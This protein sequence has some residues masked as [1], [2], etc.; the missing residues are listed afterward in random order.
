MDTQLF[1]AL[2]HVA[3][4]SMTIGEMI[5]GVRMVVDGNTRVSINGLWRWIFL[6]DNAFDV[7]EGGKGRA[8][9]SM[10]R[11]SHKW[12]LC[13]EWEDNHAAVCWWRLDWQGKR[14]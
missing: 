12:C 6:A 14:Y 4:K 7:G 9:L 8:V 11:S 13:D 10:A 3:D 1:S 5:G 2:L